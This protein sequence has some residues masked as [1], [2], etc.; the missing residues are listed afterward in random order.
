M[1]QSPPTRYGDLHLLGHRNLMQPPQGR[2]H[3]AQQAAL[4][5]LLTR[6]VEVSLAEFF[7]PGFG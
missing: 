6:R 2:G 5:A 7:A 3:G 1:F 4:R